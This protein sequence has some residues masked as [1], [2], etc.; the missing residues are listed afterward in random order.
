MRQNRLLRNGML[1]WTRCAWLTRSRMSCEFFGICVAAPRQNQVPGRSSLE[2]EKAL[3]MA[4]M[5]TS[6]AGL[7][8]RGSSP[9]QSFIYHPCCLNTNGRF[10]VKFPWCGNK[11]AVINSRAAR[12]IRYSPGP[13]QARASR[14]RSRPS[15]VCS[16]SPD[17]SDIFPTRQRRTVEG[18][19]D[20]QRA[21]RANAGASADCN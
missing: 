20:L 5:L 1:R 19:A 3:E 16:R 9:V 6:G 2:Y 18:K 15:L 17:I 8:R 14:R 12:P 4:P 21:A 7:S 11:F 13:H 10:A